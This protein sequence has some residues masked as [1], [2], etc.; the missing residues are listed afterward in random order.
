MN[1]D[2]SGFTLIEVMV[3]LA[4]VSFL[5]LAF[6]NIFEAERK[7]EIY[8]NEKFYAIL[9][10]ENFF[11]KLEADRK[12][13]DFNNLRDFEKYMKDQGF[14]TGRTLPWTK[15][16]I[17]PKKIS[18]NK[19]EYEVYVETDI[20]SES[21]SKI[22]GKVKT[23]QISVNINYDRAGNRKKL[24]EGVLKLAVSQ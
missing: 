22:S 9:S 2:K 8:N 4:L 21:N 18:L 13:G 3:A 12:S 6:F 10:L 5:G 23:L 1:K 19:M 14:E 17:P 11:E 24:T 15:E 20:D 7:A 16:V